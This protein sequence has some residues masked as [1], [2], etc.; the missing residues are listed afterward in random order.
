MLI[1]ID[2]YSAHGLDPHANC[3]VLSEQLDVTIGS[4]DLRDT[5]YRSRLERARTILAD[6]HRRATYDRLLND[7]TAI[8]DERTLD[9]LAGRPSTLQ[10][11]RPHL[12]K[13]L[14]GAAVLLTLV[15]VVIVIVLVTTVGGGDDDKNT[16]APAASPGA[17]SGQAAFSPK[18]NSASFT[19]KWRDKKTREYVTPPQSIKVVGSLDVRKDVESIGYGPAEQS[20]P[21]IAKYADTESSFPRNPAISIAADADGDL[22][23]S[24]GCET[25]YSPPDGA[26]CGNYNM[27]VDISGAKPRVVSSAAE[28]IGPYVE[29]SDSQSANVEALSVSNPEVLPRSIM[30][31]DKYTDA[32]TALV[33]GAVQPRTSSS[34]VYFLVPDS[35]KIYIGELHSTR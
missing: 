27:R 19:S 2:L 3:A 10:P 6:P 1:R 5:V 25:M 8:V 17:S 35:L 4:I 31:T 34:T 14:G 11:R 28:R 26:T 29:S 32:P 21:K 30:G 33:L 24:W 20:M 12:T 13:A 7:P 18:L 22:R 15:V 9:D 16:A 23:L